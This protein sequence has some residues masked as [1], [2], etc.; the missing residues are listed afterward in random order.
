MTDP[1]AL[2]AASQ[3]VTRANNAIYW[4][5]YLSAELRAEA[6]ERLHR[7]LDSVMRAAIDI[8]QTV[9]APS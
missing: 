3:E 1:N 5:N 9:T 6:E 2:I 8:V 7:A 4:G